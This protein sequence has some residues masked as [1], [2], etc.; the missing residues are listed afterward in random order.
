MVEVLEHPDPDVRAYA[1]YL[2]EKDYA[3]YTAK[4][5]GMDPK[6][7]DAS[8]LKRVPLRFSYEDGYFEDRYQ[9]M[10]VHSYTQFFRNL[11][12]HPN[13][14]VEL[15][16][17]ALARLSVR[18]GTLYIDAKPYENLAVYTGALDELFGFVYGRLP[19]RSLRF[20][21]KYAET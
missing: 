1:E 18:D 15:N 20:E 10:P 3:P 12:D 7:I 14:Q 5:W 8:V 13:I 16:T 9:V 17:D 11:L 4:Q 6:E 21:W 2:F 19:Y